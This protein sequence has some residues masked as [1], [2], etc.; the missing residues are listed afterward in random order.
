MDQYEQNAYG[1]GFKIIAGLDEAGRGPLA[2]PVVAAAVV[3]PRD[4]FNREIKDSKLLSAKKREQ[5]FKQIKMDA[6]SIGL[7]V[8]EP[9]IIDKVNIHNASLLAMKEAVENLTV[10]AD[11]LLVDG[12][13]RIKKDIEQEAVVAGDSVSISIASASIIAK[14]S[15]DRI[16]DIYH[17][18]YPQYN[19]CGNKGYAT[20][21]HRKAILEFGCC[22]IHRRSFRPVREAEEELP[23]FPG[24]MGGA[25]EK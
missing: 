20:A 7:G 2:G 21:D 8:I 25:P 14:V 12:I 3:L 13:F 5:L 10:P 18:Q 22:K 19:F 4:Y 15:R 11:F 24:L 6:L 1:R 17:R 16:M 9:S 23:L